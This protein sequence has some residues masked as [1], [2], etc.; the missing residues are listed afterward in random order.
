MS[1]ALASRNPRLRALV[2]GGA[3][4]VGAAGAVNYYYARRPAKKSPDR[5]APGP[6]LLAPPAP[7]PSNRAVELLRRVTKL[8]FPGT[9]A[10]FADDG[11]IS[12]P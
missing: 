8:D 2:A 5:S 6:R 10:R 7:D 3:L 12:P 4:L 1:R 11:T 9:G